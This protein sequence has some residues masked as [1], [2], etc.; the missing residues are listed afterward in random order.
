MELNRGEI[1]KKRILEDK[2][3]ENIIKNVKAT[4]EFENLELKKETEKLGR[5]VLNKQIKAS[6]AIE[7]IKNKYK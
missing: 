4:L 3:V 6:E 1:V 7:V 5:M 2:E